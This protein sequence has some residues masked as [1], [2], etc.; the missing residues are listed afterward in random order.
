MKVAASCLAAFLLC[1]I[2]ATFYKKSNDAKVGLGCGLMFPV[3]L[4]F[5]IL[6]I[7]YIPDVDIIYAKDGM[8]Q[9]ETKSFIGSYTTPSGNAIKLDWGERYLSNESDEPL[10]LYPVYYGSADQTSN[11][12][13]NEPVFI[14]PMSLI[15]KPHGIDKYFEMPEDEIQT[16]SKSVEERWILEQWETV[17]K[18][19]G[20]DQ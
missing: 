9:H 14:E 17:A 20:L 12:N 11:V 19:E 18:R 16:K 2:V 3:A 1:S 7:A 4:V 6:M 15:V 5:F 13:Q 10:I 8:M